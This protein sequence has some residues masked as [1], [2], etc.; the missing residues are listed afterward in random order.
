[1]V[2]LWKM[3]EKKHPNHPE[4]QGKLE[5]LLKILK[6]MTFK[7]ERTKLPKKFWQQEKKNFS[8]NHS[9]G[10]RS[11][12]I[13]LVNPNLTQTTCRRHRLKFKPVNRI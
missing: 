2:F 1:M 3:D 11:T 7:S 12:N 6:R 5:V 9:A 8:P 4:K 13:F 10:A